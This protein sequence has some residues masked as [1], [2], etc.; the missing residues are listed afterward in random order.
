MTSNASDEQHILIFKIERKVF[1]HQGQFDDDFQKN[2]TPPV[3]NRG[4]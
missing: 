1:P 4:M 3:K 2:E